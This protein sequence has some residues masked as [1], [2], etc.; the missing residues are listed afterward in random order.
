MGPSQSPQ[1][2]EDSPLACV[3]ARVTALSLQEAAESLQDPGCWPR[4][5][6]MDKVQEPVFG[7]WPRQ[8]HGTVDRALAVT[9]E[10]LGWE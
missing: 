5:E 7:S 10:G 2:N 8:W 4:A 3:H 6:G 9:P 1:T